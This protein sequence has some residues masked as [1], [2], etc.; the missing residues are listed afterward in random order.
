MDGSGV[1]VY[2][3][4]RSMNLRSGARSGRAAEF[5]AAQGFGDV[6]NLTGG[7]LAVQGGG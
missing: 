2:S 5:L 3:A 6:V 4:A 1:I 7:M